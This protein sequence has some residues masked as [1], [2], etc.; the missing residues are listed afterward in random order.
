MLPA[1]YQA[2]TPPQPASILLI[3][4]A[5]SIAPL[6]PQPDAVTAPCLNV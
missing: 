3:A 4:T 6:A 2:K 5:S 1:N